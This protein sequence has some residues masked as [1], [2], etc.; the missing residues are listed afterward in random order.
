MKSKAEE[1]AEL[2]NKIGK[3]FDEAS[4]YG[5]RSLDYFDVGFDAGYAA[6]DAEVEEL[7]LKHIADLTEH[8]CYALSK[9]LEA[10]NKELQARLDEAVGILSDLSKRHDWQPGMGECICPFHRQARQFLKELKGEV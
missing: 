2:K 7:K 8:P 1:L 10:E 9:E 5:R 6:R 3:E 4:W